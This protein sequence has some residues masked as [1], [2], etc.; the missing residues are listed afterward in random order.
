[1]MLKMLSM[2][3]WASARGSEVDD[4]DEA[5]GPSE[6]QGAELVDTGKARLAADELEEP[7]DEAIGL[8]EEVEIVCK[9]EEAGA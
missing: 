6:A 2:K 7:S 8:L 4:M 9:L 3:S 5:D 1:M